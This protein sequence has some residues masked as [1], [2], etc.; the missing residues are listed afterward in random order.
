MRRKYHHKPTIHLREVETGPR[1]G[2]DMCTSEPMMSAYDPI[3]PPEAGVSHAGKKL[4]LF[5]H[6]F[7]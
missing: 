2:E 4:S 1:Y 3:P 5:C 7:T 6:V